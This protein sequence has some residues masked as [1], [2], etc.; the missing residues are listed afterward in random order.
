MRGA[1][2]SSFGCVSAVRTSR[3]FR[4]SPVAGCRPARRRWKPVASTSP[5]S[6]RPIANE[7]PT[8]GRFAAADVVAN[9]VGRPP[10]TGSRSPKR[11]QLADVDHTDTGSDTSSDRSGVSRKSMPSATTPYRSWRAPAPSS[12]FAGRDGPRPRPRRP[13]VRGSATARASR[14]KHVTLTN[15]AA[16]RSAISVTASRNVKLWVAVRRRASLGVG[17]E[18]SDEMDSVHGCSLR[19]LVGQPGRVV[20]PDVDVVFVVGV[21]KAPGPAHQGGVLALGWPSLSGRARPGSE[22]EEEPRQGPRAG[23]GIAHRR[24]V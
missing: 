20:P 1:R 8:T 13:L 23:V 12:H 22:K 18:T 2:C 9:L 21:G 24:A 4:S 5:S 3:S 16:S 7:P 10:P 17:R 15:T 19:L 6:P 11:A 14:P